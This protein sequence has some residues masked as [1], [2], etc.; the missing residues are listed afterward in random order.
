MRPNLSTSYKL[1]K[2]TFDKSTLF[3][4][5]EAW[6]LVFGSPYRPTVPAEEERDDKF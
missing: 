6:V 3:A 5:A 1:H 2:S 4:G